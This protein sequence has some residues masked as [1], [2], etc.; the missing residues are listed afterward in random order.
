MKFKRYIKENMNMRTS[1][2]AGHSHDAMMNADGDGQTVKDET[3][4]QHTIFQWMVQPA[5][6]HIHNL[7]LD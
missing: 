1:K 7:D 4:H 6:G 3:E 5:N 2:V